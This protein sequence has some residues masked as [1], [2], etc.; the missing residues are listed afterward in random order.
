MAV[1]AEMHF[2]LLTDSVLHAF[3]KI[4]AELF[5]EAVVFTCLKDGSKKKIKK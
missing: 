2:F 1:L 3:R 5:K 4:P